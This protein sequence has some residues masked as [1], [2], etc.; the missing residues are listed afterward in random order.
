M[1]SGKGGERTLSRGLSGRL[2]PMV[3]MWLHRSLATLVSSAACFTRM[4]DADC[5]AVS[6]S[7]GAPPSLPVAPFRRTPAACSS[8]ACK[9]QLN[10][11]SA[12]GWW[13]FAGT[14]C[15]ACSR[16][17][18]RSWPLCTA[19]SPRRAHT[20]L[21]RKTLRRRVHVRGCAEPM[22]PRQRP[23]ERSQPDI[24]IVGVD[25]IVYGARS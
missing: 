18:W 1:R 3:C 9:S 19:P 10:A 2:V 4:S 5:A 13:D 23:G 25:G 15:A 16:R 22:M 14:R 24:T 21:P 12:V 11:A 6:T 17:C 7:H 8:S 20:S